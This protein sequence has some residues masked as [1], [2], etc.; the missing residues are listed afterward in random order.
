MIPRSDGTVSRCTDCRAKVATQAS[1]SD[2]RRGPGRRDPL[3]MLPPWC[4]DC[5]PR[6]RTLELDDGSVSRCSRCNPRSAALAA[7]QAHPLPTPDLPAYQHE[8]SITD[9]TRALADRIIDHAARAH[10]LLSANETREAMDAAGVPETIRGP[11][12]AAAAR[13]G[14]L[15]P[16]G[17]IAGTNPGNKGKPIRL[18]RSRVWSQRP[19]ELEDSKVPGNGR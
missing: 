11:R 8:R 14:L 10:D 17:Y 3:P 15:T 5:D 9:S 19:R 12:F 1:K 6:G 18:Y 13:A 2:R 7:K 4:G 16:V